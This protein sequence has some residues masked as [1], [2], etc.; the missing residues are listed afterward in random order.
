V[1]FRCPCSRERFESAIVSLGEAEIQRIID[2]EENEATEVI[3]HF[4]NQA[5]RYT[6]A[7]MAA[8]LATA[9]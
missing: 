9:R 7:D 3:C 4:C 2:E 1:A 8:I 5:Y 6:A